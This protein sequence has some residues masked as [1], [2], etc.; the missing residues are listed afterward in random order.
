MLFRSADNYMAFA[1][2]GGFPSITLPLGF[3][4]ELPFGGNLT[5]K[6]F[7]ESELLSIASVI[8]KCTGLKDIVAKE[9]K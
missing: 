2:M 8:E 7:K 5:G 4:Q 1:N 6:P 3:D 9:G